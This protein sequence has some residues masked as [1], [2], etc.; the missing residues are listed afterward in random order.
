MLRGSFS[1]HAKLTFYQKPTVNHK[2]PVNLIEYDAMET[3]KGDGKDKGQWK[4][5]SYWEGSLLPQV[6]VL[7]HPGREKIG[8]KVEPV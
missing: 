7:T 4:V 3:V 8:I 2:E 6:H 5:G 1:V